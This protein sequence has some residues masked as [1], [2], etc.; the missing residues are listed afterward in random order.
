MQLV[1]NEE[2]PPILGGAIYGNKVLARRHDFYLCGHIG[3]PAAYTMWFEI[4]RG[5]EGNDLAYIR[6]NSEGGNAFTA[7]QLVRAIH[8]CRGTV[9]CSVEGMCMSAATLIFLSGTMCEVMDHSIFMFHNY[10]GMVVGKGSEMFD[11]VNHSQ[12]WITRLLNT[13]YK[14]FLTELEIS[15]ILSGKNQWMD[16]E[17]V[18]TRLKAKLDKTRQETP[19]AITMKTDEAVKLLNKDGKVVAEITPS[20]HKKKARK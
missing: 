4:L 3:D 2:G 6:I 9:V 12:K 5:M 14:D 7:L 10:S 1:E 18:V 11:Q 15:D 17:E 8:E 16:A 19:D 13:M 20:D